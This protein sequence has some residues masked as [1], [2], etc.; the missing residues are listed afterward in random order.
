MTLLL[1][2]A[3]AQGAVRS[4]GPYEIQNEVLSAGG[5]TSTGG[6]Y[7]NEGS[8]GGIAGAP[9][10]AGARISQGYIAQIY[11]LTGP[12]V[13][14]GLPTGFSTVDMTLNGY[15]NPNGA[16]TSA[17]FEY[18]TTTSYGS[19][20]SAA[21]SPNNGTALQSVSVVLPG[22]AVNTVYHYRLSA[23]SAAGT[24]RSDDGTFTV[25]ITAQ[26]PTVA[27]QSATEL[28]V[29]SARLN[30]QVNP[31]GYSATNAFEISTDGSNWTAVAAAPSPLTGSSSVAVTAVAT[32]LQANTLYYCRAVSTNAAGA[33]R[34]P[35]TTFTTSADPPQVIPAN[36]GAI[37]SSSATL[38][39]TVI[40]K[41]RA[42][43]VWFE[44]GLSTSYGSSTAVQN[45]G[46]E[47]TS[48]DLFAPI[49]GLAAGFTYHSRMVASSQGGMAYGA[50]V[51][52]QTN[53]GA[54]APPTVMTGAA[55]G[56]TTS[57]A[58]LLGV[59]NANSGLTNAWCEYG[60][61]AALGGQS[62]QVGI[63]NTA[64]AVNPALNLSS[65]QPGTQYYYRIAA[66]NS[67]GTS[68]G[69]IL[70]F[71]TA[72]APPTVA[73][74]GS[75]PL[76]TTSVQL[77]GTVQAQNASTQVF[78][79]YGTDGTS[80]PNST[81]ATPASVS[82]NTSTG[83]SATLANL[84]QGSTYF[85]RVRAVSSGGTSVGLTATF[86]IAQLSGLLQQFPTAPPPSTGQL[87]VQISPAG[88][89]TGWRFVGEQIWRAAGSSATGLTTADREIEYRPVPAYIQP[90]GEVASIASGA[91]TVLSRVYYNTTTGGSGGL[92]VTL[93][94]DTVTTGTGRGQWR[95][96]GESD[97]QW[98][99]SGATYSGL[100]AG[101]YLVECKPVSGRATPANTSVIISDGQV[102]AP[103]ITY[104]LADSTS[105]AA[106]APLSFADVSTDA[107]KP[108]AYVGQITS[109]AGASSGFVVK[110]RVVATAAH[111]VWD[112]GTLSA[113]QG[114]QWTFQRHAEVYEPKPLV[115]RGFYLFDGYAAQRQI[116]NSPG[117]S[118]PQSQN[119]DVA[120]MYFNEAAGRD[121]F[122][123]YLAS[124]LTANEFLLSNASKML[125]GYP[126]DGIATGSQGIMHAT[127]AANV[128]FANPYAR[129]FAT[130]DIRSFGGNSGGPLCVLHSNGIWYPA[131]IYLGGNNQTIVRSIDS[132]VIDL[133]NRAD[134][135]GNGGANNTG[136]GIT[137]TSV[138]IIG[139]TSNPGAL[140]VVIAPAGAANAGAG[141]RLSPETGYRAS[142]AQKSGLNAGSYV[143]QLTTVAGYQAPTAQN[144]TV[145]GGQ[146][147]TITFTYDA[148]LT[149][150]ETWRLASFGVTTSSG[151][152]ADDADPDGD[153]MSNLAEYTAGTNPN[154]RADV[155]KTNTQQKGDG[156][157]TLT[158]SGKSGRTYILQ[159]STLLTANSWYTVTTQGPLASDG[160]VTLTDSAAPAASAFYRIQ[161][162]GP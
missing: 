52:F 2:A 132:A 19:S 27:V 78:F 144:V 142:G 99:D 37:T 129:T 12:S 108:Y 111:V 79:D 9:G 126:V 57:A 77:A 145:T 81:S 34:S 31:N 51:S 75:T 95:L 16:A 140:K 40:P 72:F 113:A 66:Q 29:S 49:S 120:A 7:G 114:L 154:D 143:L 11:P 131:G 21:L 105:G 90:P 135:S 84:L 53:A 94:P 93:M 110:A 24:N 55:Q 80:F 6:V 39:G 54:T 122:S 88:P 115:P 65:L 104:F 33:S 3:G 127:P 61:T 102:A 45:V 20:A 116:D 156:T 161:V 149:P 158:T 107:T 152:A 58:T 23:T 106:P 124:D 82:G 38:G 62:A 97:A 92:S 136:G 30:G 71:T 56:I 4:A 60:T 162:T 10:N 100:A 8:T 67:L 160:G 134:I 117:D 98:R 147:A 41:S 128:S 146:L 76:S 68:Y 118:S 157:F 47:V 121:G 89:L 48:A 50:D 63:G 36:P 14:L 155:F 32:G 25:T 85:Y 64:S 22:L 137:Q 159:R 148:V 96:L 138:S 46:A 101:S 130:T 119:L 13:V 26:A 141:W 74:G 91:T 59:V 42:T 133:F 112:D 103:A 18:G 139:S 109:N 69:S 15:V 125:V 28:G 150:Q 44:Y 123:G 86:Q 73:T 43:T 35:Q 153:G 83:V 151:N 17:T 1:C 5:A 87:T 70:S